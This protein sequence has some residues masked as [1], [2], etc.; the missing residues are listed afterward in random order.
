MKIEF[1]WMVGT[2]IGEELLHECSVLYSNHYGIWSNESEF[3]KGKN[4]KLSDDRLRDWCNHPEA[5]IYTARDG[6]ELIGYAIAVRV[7]VKGYGIISWVTQLV[8]HKNYRNRK[9]A[10]NLLFSIWGLTDD[11]AWGIVSANPYA[12]RALEKATRRRCVPYRI[13]KNVRKMISI[14]IDE[15]PYIDSNTQYIVSDN[16]S[17]INTNFFV[18][19]SNVKEMMNLVTDEF[20]PWLLGMVEEGW[21]WFAFTFNDQE[22]MGL[23]K[24]EIEE[25]LNASDDVTRKA[26]ERMD[27]SESQSWMNNTI[28]E[29]KFIIEK[30]Q[31]KKGDVL[32]DF[33]CGVGRHSIE[34]SKFGLDVTAVDYI[35][36]NIEKAK[37]SITDKSVEFI[38]DDCRYADIGKADIVT[39]LYDV[40]G[41]F[42][43]NK[44]NILILENIYK[45]LK[46]GGKAFISVMNYNMTKNIA[47]QFFSLE[48]NPENLLKLKA[49]TIME[50][51]GN[52]FNPDYFMIDERT[53]IVYRREQF[54]LG[55]RMPT[56]L[57]VR[58]KRFTKDE[59]IKLCENIGFKVEFAKCVNA[60]HWDID[61]DEFDKRAKEILIMCF[62]E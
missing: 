7:K 37:V 40:I 47:T 58:D 53:Q 18:D 4:I 16:I 13:K 34:F 50:T 56:E 10:R 57:L 54:K 21:E 38:V 35:E 30:S 14:G 51:T 39:C 31:A 17:V 52:I 61:L 5:S 36:S 32:F 9:I 48:E 8:V 44:E 42:A 46:H 1:D 3:N 55:N 43:D 41:S 25:M 22:Q 24:N 15:V 20:T 26:Y 6:E 45:N 59:I 27:F 60:K 33:G 19:H 2:F 11:F 23:S 12:I 29:A 28:N 62:K 49:S